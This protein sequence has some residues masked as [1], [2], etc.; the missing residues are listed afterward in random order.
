MTVR[1]LVAYL[2]QEWHLSDARLS[3]LR[4]GPVPRVYHNISLEVFTEKGLKRVKFARMSA[5]GLEN[6]LGSYVVRYK[7][8]S[9][10]ATAD[11]VEL[12][13][14]LQLEAM[15]LE[16]KVSLPKQRTSCIRQFLRV[17]QTPLGGWQDPV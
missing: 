8:Q 12:S 15:R 14:G 5:L 4:A 9:D 10:W 6:L 2:S 3:V 7:G 13:D 17:N 1:A 11:L 16:A